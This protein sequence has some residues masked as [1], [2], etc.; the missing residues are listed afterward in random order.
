[1]RPAL[2]VHAGGALQTRTCAVV[3]VL[4]PAHAVAYLLR[5]GAAFEVCDAHVCLRHELPPPWCTPGCC[6]PRV[7]CH[8]PHPRH[9]PAAARVQGAAV[10]LLPGVYLLPVWAVRQERCVTWMVRP[11]LCRARVPGKC[12]FQGEEGVSAAALPWA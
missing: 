10:V 2:A 7:L 6:G 9:G 1:V 3:H 8:C 5:E 12:M 11:C 4:C